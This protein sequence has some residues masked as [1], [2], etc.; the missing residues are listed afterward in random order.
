MRT[1]LLS[2]AAL[3]FVGSTARAQTVDPQLIAPITKFVDTFNKGDMTGAASTHLAD[4]ETFILDEVPPFM[5]IG[6]KAFEAWGAALDADA[7]KQGMTEPAVKLG[8]AT[9]TEVNGDHAYVVV[10]ATFTFKARGVPMREAAQMT[11][12]LKKGASGWLIHG[13]AWTGP[14]PTKV[15]GK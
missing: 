10:P 1:L 15:A 14:R 6:A 13:W 7:K 3:L 12:V 4:A 11:F 2:V 5:W 9:R 8:S